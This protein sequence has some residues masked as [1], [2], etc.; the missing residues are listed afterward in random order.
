LN[1]RD[2]FLD[3]SS[4]QGYSCEEHDLTQDDQ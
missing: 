1:K 3:H 4:P 2:L